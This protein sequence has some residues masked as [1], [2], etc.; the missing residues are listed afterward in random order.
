MDNDLDFVLPQDGPALFDRYPQ[1]VEIFIRG[2]L[3]RHHRYVSI[4]AFQDLVMDAWVHL[5]SKP[6][7]GRN[8]NKPSVHKEIDRVAMFAPA[9]M[10]GT[11]SKRF[12]AYIKKIVYNWYCAQYGSDAYD[13]STVFIALDNDNDGGIQESLLSKECIMM[14]RE[15]SVIQ[16]IMLSEFLTYLQRTDRTIYEFVCIFCQTGFYSEAASELGLDPNQATNRM[17][18]YVEAFHSLPIS[19]INQKRTMRF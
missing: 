13:H 9:R 18:G 3:N 4:E 2:F 19:Q 10:G 1:V 12:F 11:N 14:R 8:R 15:I 17:R 5:F 6:S 7:H 16:H